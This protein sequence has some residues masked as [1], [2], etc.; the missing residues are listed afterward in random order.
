MH[1]PSRPMG[2][3]SF[4]W[5]TG[6]PIPNTPLI[7]VAFF[8]STTS[9][10]F[11]CIFHQPSPISSRHT[12]FL[13]SIGSPPLTLSMDPV[14]SCARPVKYKAGPLSI[15][16]HYARHVL[17]EK[18]AEECN[19]H[20]RNGDTTLTLPSDVGKIK[21]LPGD[22]PKIDTAQTQYGWNRARLPRAPDGWKLMNARRQSVPPRHY[23]VC[24]VGAGIT[25]LYTAMILD[26]INGLSSRFQVL[27]N[28]DIL[29]ASERSGGRVFTYREFGALRP[30]PEH[31]YYD[32]GVSKFYHTVSARR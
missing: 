9:T 10:N 27:I 14:E 18:L 23:K 16:E 15:R 26:W 17:R 5:F 28:Y 4:H 12:L 31:P 29:E 6:G 24:I 22:D 2:V 19:T 25:G 13:P 32:V 7:S 21:L 3:W 20:R 1:L 8:S 30:R 11:T